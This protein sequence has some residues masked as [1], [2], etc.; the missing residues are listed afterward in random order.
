MISGIELPQNI[1]PEENPTHLQKT[2]KI[3][4][5]YAER[6]NI[7]ID[8]T[9]ELFTG[10]PEDLFTAF[11][12][13][14]WTVKESDEDYFYIIKKRNVELIACIVTTEQLESISR[15]NTGEKLYA[16]YGGG[17]VRRR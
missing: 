7:K 6:N 11:R 1:N 4:E 17:L 8:P 3:F 14:G 13:Q 10:N 5:A 15:L 9:V 12:L 16:T 2:Y